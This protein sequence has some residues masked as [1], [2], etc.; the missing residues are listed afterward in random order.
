[1]PVG[2][3]PVRKLQHLIL[4]QGSGVK[5][6]PFLTGLTPSSYPEATAIFYWGVE[7]HYDQK[8]REEKVEN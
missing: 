4:R 2:L 1:M 8:L 6:L 3:H 7:C 5:I